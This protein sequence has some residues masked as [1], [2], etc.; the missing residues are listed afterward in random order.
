MYDFCLLMFETS[1]FAANAYDFTSENKKQP[2]ANAGKFGSQHPEWIQH[3]QLQLQGTGQ[4][5]AEISSELSHP[6][7]KQKKIYTIQNL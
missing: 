6:T 4:D 5:E 2:V 3:S 1:N 7:F